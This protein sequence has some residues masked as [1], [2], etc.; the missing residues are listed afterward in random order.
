MG[1]DGEGGRCV[2]ASGGMGVGVVLFANMWKAFE[3]RVDEGGSFWLQVDLPDDS[4]N[5]LELPAP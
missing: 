1:G 5:T 3:I 2:F 4:S